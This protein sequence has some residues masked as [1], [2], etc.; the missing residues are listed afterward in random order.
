[1]KILDKFWMLLLFSV[2]F[3]SCEVQDGENLNGADTISI[4]EDISKGELAN[5]VAGVFADMRVRLGTQIDAMSVVGREYWRI[6]SSDPRWTA[7]L[8][9]GTLDDNSFY[10]NNPYAA[11]Y[12]TVRDCNLILEGLVNTTADFTEAEIAASRGLVNT[13]KAHELLMVLNMLYENGIRTNVEDPDNLGAFTGYSETLALLT[14]ML[15]TAVTDLSAGGSTFPFAIPSG[16]SGMDTPS[17]FIQFNKALAARIATY[18][19]DYP[20]T[21]TLLADSFMDLD[22]DLDAGAYFTFSLTGADIANPLFFA[23]NSTVANARI[24]HPSFIADAEAGDARLDKAPLRDAALT[25]DNLTGNN[26]VLVYKSNIDPVGI[27]RNEELILLYAEANMTIDPGEAETAIN[28]IRNAAGLGDI[29]P[30]SVDIDRILYER[31]YSLFA[32][33]GHRWIDLRRFD[34]IGDLPL[35]RAGDGTVTQFPIPQNENP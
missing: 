32:E 17:T 6:Q 7:D 16:F 18:Q 9:T 22:G 29:A 31:R 24:T 2:A 26:D 23:A 34:R 27:I 1:M 19:G 25:A 28:V 21:L 13:L 3:I 14:D 35:D 4:S 33:G 11:R 30:G 8:L 12:A 10:S 15:T 20:R 5:A